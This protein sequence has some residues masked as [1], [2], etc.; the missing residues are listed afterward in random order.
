MNSYIKIEIQ[1][2]GKSYISYIL[3]RTTFL[4]SI[5][6]EEFENKICVTIIP[7]VVLYGCETWSYTI[8][9]EC[10]PR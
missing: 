6:L 9:E 3:G 8:R 2:K 1:S 10:R 4:F 5:S 7:T